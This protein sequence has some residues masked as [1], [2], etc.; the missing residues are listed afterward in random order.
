[1]NQEMINPNVAIV[2]RNLAATNSKPARV[3]VDIRDFPRRYFNQYSMETACAALTVDSSNVH[4]YAA[5]CRIS[6]LNLDWEIIAHTI[7]GDAHVFTARQTVKVIPHLIVKTWE[8]NN[9]RNGHTVYHCQIWRVEPEGLKEVVS[10]YADTFCSGF[11]I[12]WEAMKAHR[13]LPDAAFERHAESSAP[14]YYY[15]DGFK[16][17]GFAII[18]VI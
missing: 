1:M 8:T 15:P 10:H 18:D 7:V 5:N 16:K 11:Q 6:E 9:R 2:V 13:V 12:V 14:K 17:A 3:C 4:Q